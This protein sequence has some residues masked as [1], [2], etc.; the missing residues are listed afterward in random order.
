MPDIRA[1]MLT[2]PSRQAV[3]G[4]T[5]L[6]LEKTDWNDRPVVICDSLNLPDRKISQEQNALRLLKVAAEDDADYTLF[7]EDDL[8][9]NQHLRYNLNNWAPIKHK[10]LFFGSLY[11]PNICGLHNSGDAVRHN[12][13]YFLSS[14]EYYYGSQAL[15][16]SRSAMRLVIA[17]WE[18]EPGMQDIKISRIVGRYNPI[19]HFH[20]PSLVQHI[21]LS[22]WGGVDHQT[23][24]FD[25]TFRAA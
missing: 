3:L 13:N 15:L 4:R 10:F 6:H 18:S 23:A 19:V 1:Y 16:L 21:G 7:L 20:L 11:N 24:E 9:F 25:A 8:E 22:T 17:A 2:C 5:L 12:N 14:T